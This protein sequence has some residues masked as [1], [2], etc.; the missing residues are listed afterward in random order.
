MYSGNPCGWSLF[1]GCTICILWRG[2]GIRFVALADSQTCIHKGCASH[3]KMSFG[4]IAKVPTFYLARGGT[5]CR[6]QGW[7]GLGSR[8]WPLRS[9]LCIIVPPATHIYFSYFSSINK[10]KHMYFFLSRPSGLSMKR[11]VCPCSDIRN[12]CKQFGGT[13][14]LPNPDWLIAFI[15]DI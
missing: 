5:C 2:S 12:A 14:E 10:R 1:G 13:K 3:R 9:I 15:S 11:F 4:I 7:V 6:V 8:S